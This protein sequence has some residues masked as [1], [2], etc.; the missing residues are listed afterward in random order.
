M[1]VEVPEGLR[2]KADRALLGRVLANLFRNAH[3]HGG[4]ECHIRVSARSRGERV[5]VLV[6]DDGP[7]VPE[8]ALPHLFEPFYRPDSAR[9]R[10][11]GGVGL[12][13]AIVRSGVEACGGSVRAEQARPHGL[14]VVI[15]LPA[16]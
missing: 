10:E 1:S 16:A 7:G 3:H 9:T 4:A 15:D 8:E 11:E 6:E 14:R 13:M 12:G 5:E 2:V